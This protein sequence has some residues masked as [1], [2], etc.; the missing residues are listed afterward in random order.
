VDGEQPATLKNGAGTLTDYPSLR[1]AVL[2]WRGLEPGQKLRA[3]IRVTGGPV[4]AACQIDRLCYDAGT[5]VGPTNHWV[6]FDSG[7]R[8]PIR[9]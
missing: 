4:Y 1:E 2:A 8:R 3:T 5:R 9:N 6:G 7:T